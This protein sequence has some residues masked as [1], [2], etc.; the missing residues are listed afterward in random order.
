[1]SAVPVWIQV[2]TS[3][4]TPLIASLVAYIAWQQWKVNRESL[5]ERLFERR[6]EVF[7]ETQDYIQEIIRTASI[8]DA[9]I[10][11]FNKTHQNAFFLFGPEIQIYLKE[12]KN[13]S[14]DMRLFQTKLEDLPVGEERSK[15][16]DKYIGE[17][18]WLSGQWDIAFEEFRPFM[19]FE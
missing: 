19:S 8:S 15:M 9:S 16:V 18:K 10:A 1:M 2:L 11:K 13:R 6:M 4:A 12:I 5:K 14:L 17:L 7:R 3:L